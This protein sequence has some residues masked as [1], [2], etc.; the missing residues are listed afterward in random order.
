MDSLF[1]DCYNIPFLLLVYNFYP[2]VYFV[3]HVAGAKD[4]YELCYLQNYQK[5]NVN[6]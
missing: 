2:N 4:N 5:K 3:V 6:S 1:D